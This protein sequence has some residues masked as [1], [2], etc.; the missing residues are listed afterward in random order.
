[1]VQF[2]SGKTSFFK[3]QKKETL[4]HKIN[5]K[6][7]CWMYG[8]RILQKNSPDHLFQVIRWSGAVLTFCYPKKLLLIQKKFIPRWCSCTNYSFSFLFWSLVIAVLLIQWFSPCLHPCTPTFH[9]FGWHLKQVTVIPHNN[10]MPFFEYIL[11]I[12]QVLLPDQPER[13]ETNIKSK[14]P[15][16]L[17]R[18]LI[19]G[20]KN[21]PVRRTWKMDKS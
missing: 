16:Y 4:M 12:F 10:I 1:M 19:S 8:A 3:C 17:P 7:Y 9:L 11:S 2:E 13:S 6:W 14:Q 21:A 15:I 18:I 20:H 5:F